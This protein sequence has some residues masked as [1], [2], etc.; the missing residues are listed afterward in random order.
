[1]YTDPFERMVN[2][3]YKKRFSRTQ[4]KH[5][6]EIKKEMEELKKRRESGEN[7]SIE[8]KD[9]FEKLDLPMPNE[10]EK[11]EIEGLDGRKIKIEGLEQ[12]LTH[13]SSPSESDSLDDIVPPTLSED[14]E[15]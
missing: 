6:A 15:R 3:E 14:T 10:Q 5:P 11:I 13:L 12:I 4:Y 9:L 1:M 7:I 8:L 2:D